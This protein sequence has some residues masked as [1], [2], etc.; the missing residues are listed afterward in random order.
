M[1]EDNEVNDEDD[2]ALVSMAICGE[3]I[4]ESNII[5]EMRSLEDVIPSDANMNSTIV[6]ND[7]C[8]MRNEELDIIEIIERGVCT[9][10]HDTQ[11]HG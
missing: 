3:I 10:D 4:D 1:C 9:D 2:N 6:F 7:K 11:H 5:Q 8:E